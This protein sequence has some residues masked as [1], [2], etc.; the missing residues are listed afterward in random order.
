RNRALLAVLLDTGVRLGELAGLRPGDV[1]GGQYLRVIGKGDRERIVPFTPETGRL[2][3]DWLKVRRATGAREDEPLF[4]LRYAGIKMLIRRLALET[5]IA[6]FPHK[7]RHTTATKLVRAKVDLHSVKEL[8]GH[9]QL[10]TTEAYLSLATED[11][12]AKHAE[13]S[14]FASIAAQLPERAPQRPAR[15]RLR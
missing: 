10:T 6:V 4:L 3:A 8:L 1:L 9:T 12:R 5:G 15:R 2:L 14:P 11:L 7:F 13:G